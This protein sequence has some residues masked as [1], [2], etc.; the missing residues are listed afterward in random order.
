MR[1]TAQRLMPLVVDDLGQRDEAPESGDIGE[2]ITEDPQSYLSFQVRLPDG[3]DP[4]AFGRRAD[5]ALSRAAFGR[6]SRHGNP[7]HLHPGRAGGEA[8]SCRSPTR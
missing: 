3:I 8:C 1:E 5:R 4:A 2:E 6:L 7:P